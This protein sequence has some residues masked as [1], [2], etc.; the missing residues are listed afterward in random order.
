MEDPINVKPAEGAAPENNKTKYLVWSILVGLFYG[1]P[2]LLA[3]FL[4]ALIAALLIFF[5]VVI[6][7]FPSLES[8]STEGINIVIGISTA[9]G[10]ILSIIVGIVSGRRAYRNI[11][12][13]GSFRRTGYSLASYSCAGLLGIVLFP[14]LCDAGFL[15]IAALLSALHLDSLISGIGTESGVTAIFI[16]CLPSIGIVLAYPAAVLVGAGVSRMLKR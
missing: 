15:G 12:S 9:A 2:A 3:G 1:A 4:A 10:I 7:L 14:I 8:S 16:L 13:E 6:S 11:S 5:L